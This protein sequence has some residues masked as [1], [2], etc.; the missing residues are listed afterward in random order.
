MPEIVNKTSLELKLGTKPQ[1]KGPTFMFP[2]LG[3]LFGAVAT[4]GNNQTVAYLTNGVPGRGRQLD[5]PIPLSRIDTL[6][7]DI[8]VAASNASLVFSVTTSYGQ[9]TLVWV[10]APVIVG[11]DV[12][13]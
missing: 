3:G 9:P 13:G 12:R 11:A 10:V 4:T 7:C 5:V 6:R 8:G 2:G 1:T